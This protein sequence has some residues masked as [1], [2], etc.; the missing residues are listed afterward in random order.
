MSVRTA[1]GGGG[2]DAQQGGGESLW[3]ADHTCAR[4]EKRVLSAL[5]GNG[6]ESFLPTCKAV[7]RWK[8]GVRAELDEVLFP[9]YVFVRIALGERLRVLR[10][11]GLVTLVGFGAGPTALPDSEVEALR[12]TVRMHC[13]PHPFLPI[14]QRVT[15][16]SGP[17]MGLSGILVNRRQNGYRLVVNVELIRQA[18]A[19][20]VN[21]CDVDAIEPRSQGNGENNAEKESEWKRAATRSFA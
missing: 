2:A 6:V 11:P 7:H 10:I 13:E 5:Q 17:L 14:G 12:S 19:I 18:C 20:E 15:V 21:A 4:H 9:G 1:I 16:K 8:N 3:Y